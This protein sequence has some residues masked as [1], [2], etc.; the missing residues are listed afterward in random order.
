MRKQA[1]CRG[2]YQQGNGEL[3]KISERGSEVMDTVF[4]RAQFA[5]QK[6]GRG[7]I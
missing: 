6:M 5:H 1:V 7:P 2:V 4:K 3:V